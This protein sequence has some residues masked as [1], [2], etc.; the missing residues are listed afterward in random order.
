MDSVIY[1]FTGTGNSLKIAKNLA[2]QLKDTAL[3]RIS[4]D[5]LNPDKQDKPK[6]LGIIF[7]V[8]YYGLPAM[9]KTFLDN[10]NIDSSTYVYTVATCG[11]SV[12]AAI[13]Q[14]EAALSQKGVKLSAAFSI[15]MPENYQLM[16][17]APSKEKQQVLFEKNAKQVIDI[18]RII[19]NR[20]TAKFKEKGKYFTKAFGGVI[21]STF[22]PN[23]KDRG[24]WTQESCNGCSLCSRV[25]PAGN[26]A[27]E[28]GKP[29][30]KHQCE[31][32]LACMQWCPRQSIQYNKSTLKKGRYTHPDISSQEL[33]QNNN[34]I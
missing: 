31:L 1:Y 27:M 15:V 13:R 29:S 12:G 20:E 3:V 28:Q 21:S 8:Y 22:K 34:K 25:C 2:A 9:V 33:F 26:I 4:K 19:N 30:W 16:F 10:I 7:P 18:G 6:T 23:K 11:G 32:C 14:V 17:S 5:N 24:F